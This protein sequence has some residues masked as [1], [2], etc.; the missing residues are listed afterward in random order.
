MHN[1]EAS[2]WPCRAHFGALCSPRGLGILS[3][4]DVALARDSGL[5]V[6]VYRNMPPRFHSQLFTS[7]QP[8][9]VKSGQMC[10][11]MSAPCTPPDAPPANPSYSKSINE[12]LTGAKHCADVPLLSKLL[13]LGALPGVHTN[14]PSEAHLFVVP[15]LGGFI[16]RVS[17]AMTQVLDRDQRSGRGI[18]DDIFKHL[19]HHDNATAARHL[20]LLTNSC[21][22]CLRAPCYRCA[23]WQIPRN[24][25]PGITLAATLGPSWAPDAVPRGRAAPGG[26]R[27]LRQLVVPPN[28]ME[29]EFHA[30]KYVPLC[31]DD[32]SG[33]V[34]GGGG[35]GGKGIGG[36]RRSGSG[37]GGGGGG[38]GGGGG[39]GA[40]GKRRGEQR[41]CRPNTARKE[42]LLFYQGAHSFN[43]IRD[44][45]LGELHRAVFYSEPR[46]TSTSISTSDATAA[47]AAATA[48]PPA[49]S[50]SSASA[51]P[52]LP[53]KPTKPVCDCSRVPRCCVNASSG[54]AFFHTRSHWH[55][56]TPLGFG[57]TIEWMQRSRFCVC[58]PGDVPYNK[59]YF[60]ALLAGCVPVLFSFR[61]QVPNERNWWKPRK[62]PGQRDI[63]PFYEQI[64]HTELGVV[65]VSD[66]EADIRG[67]IQRLRDIP[68]A[69]V[70]AKQRAI[71][72][73]RHLLLYD[74][75][76]SREDAFTCMLRQL[77]KQLAAL[78]PEEGRQPLHL[79]D[80]RRPFGREPRVAVQLRAM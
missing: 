49:P 9:E 14:N 70:E 43:G 77:V 64:N 42:L 12:W 79:P 55:P 5:R 67:F 65:L 6:Y 80:S 41:R 30:P 71:E 76:G 16:E 48:A 36:A 60:T 58:P 11:F 39:G 61:S 57:A 72:R 69:V 53:A 46:P 3:A 74:M 13:A 38:A 21:G 75:S 31:D 7:Q 62:G 51:S 68:D 45:I 2:A 20:F 28:I 22:G 18:A 52:V 23:T 24:N 10:D 34:G 8:A 44:A 1:D 47:A 56:V 17:P 32:G 40:H 73:V 37:F 29:T 35:G 19:P 15:F 59:R 27:W 54:V 26:R 78:P 25:Y 4:A 63:D 66:G 50:A 33:S